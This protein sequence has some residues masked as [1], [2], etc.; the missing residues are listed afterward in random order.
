MEEQDEEA[1]LDR[2][3]KSLG[4][5]RDDADLARSTKGEGVSNILARNE[6]ALH[7]MTAAIEA[8]HQRLEQQSGLQ[9]AATLRLEAVTSKCAADLA[10]LRQVLETMSVQGRDQAVLL[11]ALSAPRPRRLSAGWFAAALVVLLLGVG[12]AGWI[13]SGYEPSLTSAFQWLTTRISELGRAHGAA[14][15]EKTGTTGTQQ[16]EESPQP[17]A[18]TA[19]LEFPSAETSSVAPADQVP[20]PDPPSPI[21][22]G[23]VGQALPVAAVERPPAVVTDAAPGPAA[24]PTAPS[25]TDGAAEAA[26]SAPQQAKSQ[27]AAVRSPASSE[28][29]AGSAIPVVPSARQSPTG[30][31]LLLRAT[32]DTWVQVRSR[33]GRVLLRR[34]MKD[35]ETW[36]VPAEPDLLLDVGNAGDLKLVVNGVTANVTGAKGGV[37]HDWPLNAELRAPPAVRSAR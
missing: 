34:I 14:R 31:Q 6:A 1:L 32:G 8:M 22:S 26:P 2:L 37:I 29:T 30:D 28:A 24:E 19:P 35:G 18:Q 36:P 16:A 20:Q 25:S 23:G 11:A 21:N 7:S 9:H 12:A 17:S 3:A 33:N 15:D 13:V 10:S 27:W 5:I 4:A